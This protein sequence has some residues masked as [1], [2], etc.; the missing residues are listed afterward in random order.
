[1]AF[2]GFKILEK[3]EEKK[4][5][6]QLKEEFG[7]EKIPGILLMRG[8]ERIFLYQGK[9]SPKEISNFEKTISIE[10]I[11][12]YFAKKE[13]EEF[14]LSLDGVSLLKEQ[15]KKGI[16][17]L[18]PEQA[19]EWMHGSELNISTGKKQFLIMKHKEY[20]LGTGKASKEKISN[21][22]PKNRRLKFKN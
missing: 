5:L 14:R 15:I 3:N 6:S 13:R 18:S 21:F 17:E 20:Y 11:G 2:E 9:L 19:K 7:I 12:I 16:F 4:L 8:A 10:R 1:M 22:V